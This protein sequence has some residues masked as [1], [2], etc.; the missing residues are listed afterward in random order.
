MDTLT[1]CRDEGRQMLNLATCE[2]LGFMALTTE[3]TEYSDYEDVH[4]CV[5]WA[6]ISHADLVLAQLDGRC[7][8]ARTMSSQVKRWGCPE[9][10]YY[11]AQGK[12]IVRG[13][14]SKVKKPKTDA[15]A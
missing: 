11:I 1:A 2:E 5:R 7:F 4:V 14:R 3:G 13:Y 12:D 6:P 10:K 15:R 8:E 9:N